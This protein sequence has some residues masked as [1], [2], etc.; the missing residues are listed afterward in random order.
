MAIYSKRGLIV[1]LV[2]LM[3]AMIEWV[4]L[5]IA[6]LMGR[7]RNEAIVLCYHG[8]SAEQ[9]DRFAWQMSK[10]ARRAVDVRDL[11]SFKPQEN[12][13]PGVCVT[14]DD[15]F[16]NLL[17]NALPAI[18][19]W[20]IPATIFVVSENAGDRPRWWM[21]P[22]NPEAGE[23]LISTAEMC[24]LVQNYPCRIG[25]HTRTHLNLT[26]LSLSALRRELSESKAELERLLAVPVED[27]ALPYG[28]YDAQVLRESYAAGYRRVFTL[29]PIS[30]SANNPTRKIGRFRMSPDVWRIE[31]LLTCAGAYCWLESCQAFLTRVRS[32]VTSLEKEALSST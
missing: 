4:L 18:K 17:D 7:G 22:H 28:R 24:Q 1:R 5:K 8:I 32:P 14:L 20:K 29:E 27:L 15:G 2:F 11:T 13:L 26:T 30:V 16:A 3:F 31:F 25:S 12:G 19:Q 23:R 21:S 6:R 9:R 10:I